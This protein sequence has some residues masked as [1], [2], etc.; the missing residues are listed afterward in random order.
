MLFNQD[1]ANLIE[2]CLDKLDTNHDLAQGRQKLALRHNS[3]LAAGILM[4]ADT[5]ADANSTSQMKDDAQKALTDIAGEELDS[6]YALNKGVSIMT[7]GNVNAITGPTGMSYEQGIRSL[8]YE[9]DRQVTVQQLMRDS[10]KWS[11]LSKDNRT[12]NAHVWL[13]GYRNQAAKTRD[14]GMKTNGTL[15][16]YYGTLD[17]NRIP[18]GTQLLLGNKR[19]SWGSI[20]ITW[21]VTDAA[22]RK[23]DGAPY[24]SFDVYKNSNL[25]RIANFMI[26]FMFPETPVERGGLVIDGGGAGC[27]RAISAL[28]QITAIICPAVV[29]DSAPLCPHNIGNRGKA[30]NA[31]SFADTETADFFLEKS[32]LSSNGF[33]NY[34]TRFY[35][36]RDRATTGIY[37]K[38][39]Y[40]TFNYVIEVTGNGIAVQGVF[41]FKQNGPSMGPSVPYIAALIDAARRNAGGG[42]NAIISALSD[43]KPTGSV[44][45]L[46]SFP[47]DLFTA[48][49]GNRV[50][51]NIALQLFERICFDIKRCG[52]WEQVE[53]VPA[54]A[55]H[56][57]DIGVTMLG[58]GDILCMVQARLK[59]LCG[60]W[61][62]EKSLGKKDDGAAEEDG[63]EEGADEEEEDNSFGSGGN[64]EAWNLVFF[65]NPQNV[66]ENAIAL[67]NIR[68]I[69]GKLQKPLRIIDRDCLKST[70]EKLQVLYQKCTQGQ[71]IQSLCT[72]ND[73]AKALSAPAKAL[74]AINLFNVAQKCQINIELLSRIKIREDFQDLLQLCQDFSSEYTTDLTKPDQQDNLTTFVEK[75]RT[76]LDQKKLAGLLNPYIEMITTALYSFGC[77]YDSVTNLCENA[78]PISDAELNAI[79]GADDTQPVIP[80]GSINPAFVI[81]DA[82]GYFAGWHKNISEGR[83]AINGYLQTD[84]GLS[85]VVDTDPSS[86]ADLVESFNTNILGPLKTIMTSRSNYSIAISRIVAASDDSLIKQVNKN[87]KLKLLA[88]I[89]VPSRVSGG[90]RAVSPEQLQAIVQKV[91][92]TKAAIDTWFRQGIDYSQVLC[93]VAS[94][95]AS[96]AAAEG[97]FSGGAI[98]S[99]DNP[100]DY[101]DAIQNY[102][103]MLIQEVMGYLKLCEN[104]DPGSP[105]QIE[106]FSKARNAFCNGSARNAD[107]GQLTNGPQLPPNQVGLLNQYYDDATQNIISFFRSQFLC[108]GGQATQDNINIC[109][110]VRKALEALWSYDAETIR[111]N[112]IKWIELNDD[113]IANPQAFIDRAVYSVIDPVTN[114]PRAFHQSEWQRDIFG[115]NE[116][117]GRVAGAGGFHLLSPYWHGVFQVMANYGNPD[118]T[119]DPTPDLVEFIET[120]EGLYQ[121]NYNQFEAEIS[122]YINELLPLNENGEHVRIDFELPQGTQLPVGAQ[123][124][125][126][127]NMAENIAGATAPQL[128]SSNQAAAHPMDN[129]EFNSP[130]TK[131]VLTSALSDPGVPTNPPQLTPTQSVTFASTGID[132]EAQQAELEYWKQQRDAARAQQQRQRDAARAQQE[133]EHYDRYGLHREGAILHNLFN[134]QERVPIFTPINEPYALPVGPGTLKRGRAVEAF[135]GRKKK[136]TKKRNKKKKITKK[137]GKGKG[138]KGKKKMTK[139]HNKKKKKTRARGKGKKN[140]K[141]KKNSKGRKTAKKTAG[142]KS[143]GTGV[144]EDLVVPFSKLNV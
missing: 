1:V 60:A 18:I 68:D 31:Y 53:S 22:P 27:L 128:P 79:F 52:D 51:I 2:K 143:G 119:A 44:L 144:G 97:D 72:T 95:A 25:L 130:H 84:I 62:N 8:I 24:Y 122:E 124:Q 109:I 102:F 135:G 13:T 111:M 37:D 82:F 94:G 3:R 38:N 26:T 59:G 43:V 114:I 108:Q 92:S 103:D 15:D 140:S 33:K 133:Q 78:Q 48:L 45:S 41:P 55:K 141:A 101:S 131:P 16:A 138:K 39:T 28:P 56:R 80:D 118:P 100:N 34:V 50:D 49:K 9:P 58:T 89:P 142:K 96:G 75:Y 54:I 21:D 81:D 116:I 42:Y 47:V 64:P 19:H 65:R 105:L 11:S 117:I 123:G 76:L 107:D 74:S 120:S 93:S 125:S 113:V 73:P 7:K 115:G 4:L 29:G 139:K 83:T 23:L 87:Y 6:Q 121:D 5:I 32:N 86:V 90:R 98:L 12:A 35:Y 104:G 91:V 132:L 67:F 61:H 129:E 126:S 10:E 66:D 20:N 88:D 36:Q 14:E 134:E 85:S 17:V 112:A 137:K 46:N 40:S 136:M 106:G 77:S 110:E 30:R 70:V 71:G 69:V 99:N 63:D 57:P 127:V